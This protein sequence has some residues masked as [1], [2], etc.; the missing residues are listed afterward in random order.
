MPGTRAWDTITQHVVRCLEL[1]DRDD[2]LRAQYSY[3][4][5]DPVCT[6]EILYLALQDNIM[7]DVQYTAYNV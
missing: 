7:Y 5:G 4:Y 3:C 1:W 6:V 2:L